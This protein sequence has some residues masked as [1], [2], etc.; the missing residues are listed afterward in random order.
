[1]KRGHSSKDMSIGW[2]SRKGRGVSILCLCIILIVSIN[3]FACDQS[4]S[5][6]EGNTT[7]GEE[8]SLEIR[9]W[10]WNREYGYI[11]AKGEVRNMSDKKLDNVMVN[12][13][14]YDDEMDFV[15]SELD[16]VDPDT[17]LPDGIATF[18]VYT[19]DDRRIVNGKLSF[20]YPFGGDITSVYYEGQ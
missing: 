12:V 8:P 19:V 1:M 17:I 9:Y 14:Y 3:C 5:G 11:I 13:R 4:N 10:E 15:K 2:H 7:S 18:E 20:Q 6:T 16:V